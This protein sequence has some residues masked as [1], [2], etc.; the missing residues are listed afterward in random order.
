MTL[1]ITLQVAPVPQPSI[2]T[3]ATVVAEAARLGNPN[4]AG[5]IA[6]TVPVVHHD[7]RSLNYRWET[8]RA[9]GFSSFYCTGG[10]LPLVLNQTIYLSSDLSECAQRSCAR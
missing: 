7:T 1:N 3:T 9:T 8:D 5:A 10:T 2:V 4:S 6:V